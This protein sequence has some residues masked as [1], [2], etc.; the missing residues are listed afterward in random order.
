MLD[1][2]VG[3]FSGSTLVSACTLG[4]SVY[5]DR[6]SIY[7]LS[8]VTTVQKFKDKSKPDMC[9]VTVRN[10]GNRPLYLQQVGFFEKKQGSHTINNLKEPYQF[11]KGILPYYLPAGE[12]ILVSFPSA[13]IE[14]KFGVRDSEGRNYCKL[15]KTKYSK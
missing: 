7:E 9:Y 4:Y 1:T 12:I 3:F 5:K 10:I 13:N 8:I 14:G 2:L 11:D 15:F 6:K